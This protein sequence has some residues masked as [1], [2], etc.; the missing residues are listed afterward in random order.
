MILILYLKKWLKFVK[1]IKTENAKNKMEYF[2]NPHDV[3]TSY[4]VI[5][6]I[7]L[8]RMKFFYNFLT[9]VEGDTNLYSIYYQNIMLW[10]LM[11]YHIYL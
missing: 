8:Y 1:I 3:Y 9:D 6:H 11:I 7:I 5:I 2:K 10:Y 4:L